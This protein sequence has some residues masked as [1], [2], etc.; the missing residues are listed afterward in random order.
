MVPLLG[1]PP[2]TDDSRQNGSLAW[3]CISDYS[4]GYLRSRRTPCLYSCVRLQILTFLE[5]QLCP[6][7][8]FYA[9]SM[10]RIVPHSLGIDG[11]LAVRDVKASSGEP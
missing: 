6:S 5:K 2:R 8:L 4:G 9:Y 11:S 3:E 10:A 7:M 1:W